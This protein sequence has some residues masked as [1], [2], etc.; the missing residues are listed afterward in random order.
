[1][2]RKLFSLAVL[3]ILYGCAT[4]PE[5]VIDHPPVSSAQSVA[6]KK[7]SLPS[8]PS[9]AGSIPRS[10]ASPVV[11]ASV[12]IRV[13]FTSQAPLANW[14]AMH[15]ETCE[16]AAML[17]VQRFWVGGTLSP[18]TAEDELQKI[19]AWETDHG[20]GYDV[21]MPQLLEVAKGYFGLSGHIDTNV[22]EAHI[23]ELLSQGY[24]IVIPAAGRELGNPYFSGEG[25]WYHA[26]TIVGYDEKNFITNDPGTKRGESYKYPYATL[27]SAIHDWTG[28]KEETNTGP[29]R[30]LVLS[31]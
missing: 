22:T 27:L 19:V 21:T 1:M 11:K 24:P 20:Y 16:E 29:K 6:S 15:E 14:D 5:V 31:K 13:P 4:K 3:C 28:V 7:S 9:T 25:P 26:L 12:L 2:K 23:K 18:Q 17:M 10:S 30:M 8:I